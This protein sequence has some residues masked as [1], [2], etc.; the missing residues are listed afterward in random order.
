MMHKYFLWLICY[1]NISHFVLPYIRYFTFFFHL[2]FLF[3][4]WMVGPTDLRNG[5]R[6]SQKFNVCSIR[7]AGDYTSLS[8]PQNIASFSTFS[9][10]SGGVENIYRQFTQKQVN[11]FEN[12]LWILIKVLEFSK[13]LHE[14]RMLHNLVYIIQCVTWKKRKKRRYITLTAFIKFSLKWLSCISPSNSSNR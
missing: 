14:R 2:L 10:F 9:C 3:F 13:K 6:Q 8:F 5:N 1:A 11:Q 12:C 7:W 4:Y